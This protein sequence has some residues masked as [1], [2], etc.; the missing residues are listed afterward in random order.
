MEMLTVGQVKE[1]IN[2]H[3]SEL[4]KDST[5]IVINE[6]DEFAFTKHLSY[7]NMTGAYDWI[8][9]DGE[10]LEGGYG[11]VLTIWP[12]S[13]GEIIYGEIGDVNHSG[14]D[15]FFQNFM[16]D[17]S[18]GVPDNL[19]QFEKDFEKMQTKDDAVV[20]SI[21]GRESPYRLA[22]GIRVLPLDVLLKYHDSY[23]HE[24]SKSSNHPL[25]AI[26]CTVMIKQEF[27]ANRLKEGAF[28]KKYEDFNKIK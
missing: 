1:F 18:D 14:H 16:F 9:P 27:N 15:D 19:E 20:S 5:V 21:I 10:L 2:Q 11:D 8:L 6:K 17:G 22:T 7:L 28:V 12:E 23:G 25:L 4:H 13:S 3:R 24:K 26:D